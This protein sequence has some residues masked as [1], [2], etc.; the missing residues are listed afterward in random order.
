MFFAFSV[1]IFSFSALFFIIN[2]ACL[3]VSLFNL[4]LDDMVDGIGHF[5]EFQHHVS[6]MA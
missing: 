6:V 1:L 5:P 4:Q 2:N 3:P